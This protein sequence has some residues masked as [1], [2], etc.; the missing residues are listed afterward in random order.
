META[1]L[2]AGEGN[3]RWSWVMLMPRSKKV[4]KNKPKPNLMISGWQRDVVA[5]GRVSKLEEESCLLIHKWLMTGRWR[6]WI[7]PTCGKNQ[8]DTLSSRRGI[9][10]PHPVSVGCASSLPFQRLQCES[11]RGLR[12]WV[13]WD[14]VQRTTT[15][16]LAGT[17]SA[18]GS[19]LIPTMLS[20][21]CV[22]CVCE[23]GKW[24]PTRWGLFL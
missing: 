18:R 22:H 7:N 12:R 16:S 20:H 15:E 23:P 11:K 24:C 13:G 14:M 8:V 4:L 10:T 6:K 5:T 2:T 1:C 19:T 21:V 9:V 3:G 17:V